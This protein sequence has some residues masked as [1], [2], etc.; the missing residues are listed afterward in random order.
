MIALRNI[1]SEEIK[2]TRWIKVQV[3]EE[4][5]G[6][7]SAFSR[8]L[9][10]VLRAAERPLTTVGVAR[11]EG[12]GERRV[13]VQQQI[14]VASVSLQVVHSNVADVT[15]DA[16][17]CDAADERVRGFQPW[18]DAIDRGLGLGERGRRRRRCRIGCVEGR[19]SCRVLYEVRELINA[20]LPNGGEQIRGREALIKEASAAS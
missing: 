16:L 10:D 3:G 18:I 12:A 6:M 7:S 5:L 4:H 19:Q 14:S 11:V 15:D 2:P 13:G 20:V 8:V 1:E 9:V 17:S